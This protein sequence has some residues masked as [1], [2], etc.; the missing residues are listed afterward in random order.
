MNGVP[1]PLTNSAGTWSKVAQPITFGWRT[2]SGRYG[3]IGTSAY[4]TVTAATAGHRSLMKFRLPSGEG[5]ADTVVGF[6]GQMRFGAAGAV[7]KAVLLDSSGTELQ[8]VTIDADQDANIN[9]MGG[10]TI[11]FDEASLTSLSYGT[12]YYVGLEVV[13]GS[14]GVGL[15]GINLAEAEDREAYPNGLNRC[16]GTS[17]GGAITDNTL[18]MPT[19]EIIIDDITPASG[20]GGGAVII[21]GLGQTGIGSF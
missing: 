1:Y 6:R 16:L 5:S 9:A 10:R 4:A 8:S 14:G 20:S 13:S 11:Y 18:V 15:G 7:S 2:A 17:T 3:W 21:G 19:I 12:D